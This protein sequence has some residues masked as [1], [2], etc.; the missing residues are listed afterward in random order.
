MLLLKITVSIETL[1]CNPW[2]LYNP[3]KSRDLTRYTDIYFLLDPATSWLIVA[4]EFSSGLGLAFIGG[5]ILLLTSMD[6]ARRARELK[7]DNLGL[8]ATFG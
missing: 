5:R 2:Q 7:Y 3:V 1:R 6:K 8:Y 4:A